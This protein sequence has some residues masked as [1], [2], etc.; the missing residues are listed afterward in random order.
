MV[1][2]ASAVHRIHQLV[3]SVGLEV[4]SSITPLI[5]RIIFHFPSPSPARCPLT[6]IVGVGVVINTLLARLAVDCNRF[7]A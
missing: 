6:T 7:I 3:H 1:T 5:C 2:V 4:S